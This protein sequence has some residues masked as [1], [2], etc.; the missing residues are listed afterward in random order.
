M[1]KNYSYWI[2]TQRS[3][4]VHFSKGTDAGNTR[5]HETILK[6][7]QHFHPYITDVD[8]LIKE[9]KERNSIKIKA[10]VIPEFKLNPNQKHRDDW[11][12]PLQVVHKEIVTDN[13]TLGDG[14]SKTLDNDTSTIF[15]ID[16]R[17]ACA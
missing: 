14:Y 8:E 17:G 5:G 6:V 10:E 9:L 3:I 1:L 4:V 13:A 7:E 16:S 11:I 15:Q 2:V 12:C